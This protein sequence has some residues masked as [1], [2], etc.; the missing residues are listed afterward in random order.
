VLQFAKQRGIKTLAITDSLVS[1]LAQYAGVVL[2]A[3]HKLDSFIES[4]TA[5][6]SLINAIATTLGIFSKKSTMKSLKELEKIW[7][8]QQ[9][10]Y[11]TTKHTE[12][13]FVKKVGGKR[14]RERR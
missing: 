14:A 2:T 10:Y 6:L 12:E 11:N 7:E 4:F 13:N 1:P 9:V 3:Q 8:R 5:P